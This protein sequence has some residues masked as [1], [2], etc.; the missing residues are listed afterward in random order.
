MVRLVRCF[1]GRFS[2]LHRVKIR[3][4]VRRVFIVT[5]ACGRSTAK[6]G[7]VRVLG[8]GRC[9]SRFAARS[10]R[11]GIFKARQPGE[12]WGETWPPFERVFARSAFVP[13][14][15]QSRPQFGEQFMA[16]RGSHGRFRTP[17][18]SHV[19]PP[20]LASHGG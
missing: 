9:W 6:G 4:K 13:A 18:Y 10:S 5:L 12:R 11:R 3:E 14:H 19:L 8:A 17:L 2:S 16:A 20:T 15:Q 1:G 7:V